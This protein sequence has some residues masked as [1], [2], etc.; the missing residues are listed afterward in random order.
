[1]IGDELEALALRFRPRRFAEVAGQTPS[2]AV[3]YQMCVRRRV[4]SALLFYGSHGSG[5]TTSARI[6]AA[7]LNC[8]AEP[9][10]ADAWPC[11]ECP[12]CEAV[13]ND[14]GFYFMEVDAASNGTVDRVRDIRDTVQYSTGTARRVVLLDEAHSMSRDAGNALLKVLEEPPP[15][16]TFILCTTERSKILKTVDSRCVPFRFGQLPADV[17]AQRLAWICQQ[18]SIPA[19]S[20]LLAAIAEAA[21]G[22]MRDAVM[23]LDQLS[24]VGI[25]DLARYQMLTGDTDFAPSLIEAALAGDNAVLFGRLDQV[26]QQNGDFSAVSARLVHCLRDLLVLL[27]GGTVTAQGASLE[28]RRALAARLDP[29]RVGKAMTVLWELQTRAA[30]TD[31]RASLELACVVVAERLRSSQPGPAPAVNGHSLTLSQMTNGSSIHA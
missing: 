4:P 20:G 5:K 19:E 8:K 9:G 10:P 11:L 26:L 30:R 29:V 7:A 31:P 24:S 28:A 1:M 3:L 12:E 16:T 13:W 21:G 15:G 2:I 23:A 14:S 18:A 27:S 17:I 6:T 22:A 25:F